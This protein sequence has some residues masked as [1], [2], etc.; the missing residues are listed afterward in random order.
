MA[1][2]TLL[3]IFILLSMAMQV[4]A[5]YSQAATAP[6]PT[7]TAN[8]ANRD[9]G[10][11]V[12]GHSADPYTGQT[13]PYASLL[14][15][16]STQTS[17]V[18]LNLLCSRHQTIATVYWGQPLPGDTVPVRY[19]PSLAT[20]STQENWEVSHHSTTLT[21]PRDGNAL[22]ADLLSSPTITLEAFPEH[23]PSMMARFSTQGASIALQE[24]VAI[25]GE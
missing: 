4:Y 22:F 15:S 23:A 13:Y 11:W 9:L 1:P 10:N 6:Q 2:S 3:P 25:C 20:Q 7:T 12:I 17:T 16:T 19:T 8:E 14:S 21:Y 24:L 5:P 18:V